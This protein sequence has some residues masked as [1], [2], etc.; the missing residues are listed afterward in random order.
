M[1]PL[2]AA[3]P[4]AHRNYGAC[5]GTAAS[6]FGRDVACCATLVSA[7]G[8]RRR[9]IHILSVAIGAVRL[10]YHL[11]NRWRR[12]ILGSRANIMVRPWTPVSG[13]VP[14][15]YLTVAIHLR[16]GLAAAI[17]RDAHRIA[18]TRHWLGRWHLDWDD[19]ATWVPL[20]RA[21]PSQAHKNGATHCGLNTEGTAWADAVAD[22]HLPKS[23]VPW[24]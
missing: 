9:A 11:S 16:G 17:G 23:S 14:S 6:L 1:Q 22:G 21:S 8:R 12:G 7:E 13:T 24:P 15:C 18:V 10:P 4:P 5:A 2:S 3:F 20:L 19:D